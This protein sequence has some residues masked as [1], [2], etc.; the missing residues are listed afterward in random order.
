MFQKELD[1]DEGKTANYYLL[2]ET[3]RPLYVNL[4]ARGTPPPGE[5]QARR[6]ELAVEVH[7]YNDEGRTID[8]AAVEQGKDIIAEVHVANRFDAEIENLAL[9]HIVPSGW[10]IAN[11][12]LSD[13]AS[14]ASDPGFHYRDI[15]DDRV[16]TYFS[17]KRGESRNFRLRFT[18]AYAGHYYMPGVAVEDMYDA[19]LSART[20]GQWIDVIRGE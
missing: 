6:S 15:R 17:L 7:F 3:D 18:A 4:L 12:R 16:L 10:E 14:A 2:N 8:P 20:K 19:E 11:E 1:V 5:E 13:D 9:T